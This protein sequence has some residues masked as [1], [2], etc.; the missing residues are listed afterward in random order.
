MLRPTILLLA[1]AV[2]AGAQSD[3][4]NLA[5]GVLDQT[6]QARQAIATHDAAA[7][8]THIRNAQATVSLIQQ[9]SVNAQTP[10]LVP[11]FQSV[12]TT[13]TVTPVKKHYQMNK[14]SSIRGVNQQTTT[15]ELNV[16]SAAEKLPVAL[17][18]LQ[19]G[20]WGQADAALA[21]IEN[22]VSVSQGSGAAPLVMARKNLELARER[23]A[24][25]KYREAEVPLKSAAQA[26]ETYERTAP[27]GQAANID[28]AR[29]AMQGYAD[30]VTHEHEDAAGRIDN[31][32]A[33]VRQWSGQ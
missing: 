29:Q 32:L 3:V 9:R 1:A 2:A 8:A 4:S 28:A 12:E 30:H 17:T 31:W 33:M 18:S 20:D 19:A 23:V 13:T 7:A 14:N 27:G 10:L 25:G 5:A 24:A 16:S 6:R 15:A 22:S 11:I 26:L 21:A